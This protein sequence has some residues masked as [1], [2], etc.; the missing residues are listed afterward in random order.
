MDVAKRI[1]AWRKAKGLTRPELAAAVGVTDAA[2]YHWEATDW[3]ARMPRLETLAKL[4]AVFGIT[5]AR[6]WGPLP[7]KKAS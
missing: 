2:A 3:S 5:M 7:R 4:V 1:A 6:F